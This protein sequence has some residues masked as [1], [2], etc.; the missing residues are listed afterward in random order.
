MQFRCPI[1]LEVCLMALLALTTHASPA[2][3]QSSLDNQ[4]KTT[5]VVFEKVRIFD[6]TSDQ[7]SSPLNVLVV[8]NKIQKISTASISAPA[9]TVVTRINGEGR[10]LMPGLIDNHTH[11][12]MET[13]TE[14]EML[15]PG[16][17]VESFFQ[18]ARE[19]ATGMLL[20]GFTSARDVAGPVFA[21]KKAID[22]G[23]VAG[24]RIWPSGAMISQ[25]GGHGDFRSLKEL[26]RTPTTPLSRAEVYGIGAIADGV[27][28][29]LRRTREQLM[30]G[31]SQIKLA[32]GGGVSSL[33]DPLDVSQYTESELRAA[34]EAAANWNTYVTVHAYTPASIQTAIRAGVRCI[35]HGQL[36]DEPTAQLMAKKGIWLSIQP[37]LGDEDA[38]PKVGES[39]V[40]QQQVARGTDNAYNLA[41]KYKLKTAWGTDTLF[42]P[43]LAPRQG[44]LLAKMVRWYTPAQVLK[45]ATG[46]NAEL[47]ALSGPRNPYPGKLGVVEE[48]AL[49]DLLL[50]NGDPLE[51]I[52]LIENPSKNFVVIMKD[53]K[54]YKNLLKAG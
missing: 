30:Q 4:Q 54:V 3:S 21:L 5:S 25:S 44:A 49:A 11:L 19:N 39:L 43:K 35:E 38:N 32:A 50:V 33:Y 10:V 13:A 16:I 51:N 34:V 18:R 9:G 23:E 20:R 7:L 53:G 52:K 24:P 14:A 12:F 31:A 22:R 46:T 15:D 1:A 28:E 36:I 6:G 40:K 26:P 8:G 45:M 41:K 48:G 42:A 29:V 2:Q 47:L 27:D 17:P 37:F